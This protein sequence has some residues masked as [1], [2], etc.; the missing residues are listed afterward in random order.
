LRRHCDGCIR[1]TPPGRRIIPDR[2]TGD[3]AARSGR[4][5]NLC[6]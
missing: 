4:S 3:V 1:V 6:R 2:P 5:H